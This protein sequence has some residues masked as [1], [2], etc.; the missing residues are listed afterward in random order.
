[1]LERLQTDDNVFD[2]FA[3]AAIGCELAARSALPTPASSQRLSPAWR[4][5][6]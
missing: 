6:S 2:R 3:A 4:M 5:A 1:M